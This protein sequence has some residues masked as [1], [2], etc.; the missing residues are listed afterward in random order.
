M[1]TRQ[2]RL[3]VQVDGLNVRTAVCVVAMDTHI[4][5]VLAGVMEREQLQNGPNICKQYRMK[6]Y[7]INVLHF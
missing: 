6:D 4:S 2:W 3:S 5:D 7:E 1:M